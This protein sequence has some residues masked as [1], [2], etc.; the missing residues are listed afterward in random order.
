[1]TALVIPEIVLP[2]TRCVP[3]VEVAEGA[4]CADVTQPPPIRQ[5]RRIHPFPAE[6]GT[7]GPVLNRSTGFCQDA[8]FVLL[9][10]S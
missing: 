4:E 10:I 9:E 1:M 7:N 6:N 8:Q 3:T 2:G 5:R